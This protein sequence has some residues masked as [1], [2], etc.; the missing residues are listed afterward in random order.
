MEVT[1]VGVHF[2]D[3]QEKRYE[4]ESPQA[5]EKSLKNFSKYRFILEAAEVGCA[6]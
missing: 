4:S 3:I 5:R 6:F 2:D 1:E